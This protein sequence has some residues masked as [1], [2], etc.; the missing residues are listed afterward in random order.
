MS[1]E[2]LLAILHG[3]SIRG[4]ERST[5]IALHSKSNRDHGTHRIH[6]YG[7]GSRRRTEIGRGFHGVRELGRGIRGFQRILAEEFRAVS[8][9]TTAAAL[10]EVR[11]DRL[12]TATALRYSVAFPLVVQKKATVDSARQ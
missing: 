1:Q 4:D 2:K 7:K 10:F 5:R 6:G 11:S 8:G 9:R 12:S 3:N